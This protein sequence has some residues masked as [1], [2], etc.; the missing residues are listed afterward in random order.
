[1]NSES[2]ILLGKPNNDFVKLV[3]KIGENAQTHSYDLRLAWGSH[4]TVAR[5]TEKVDIGTLEKLIDLVG[6]GPEIKESIPFA[7]DVGYFQIN[8]SG[9]YFHTYKRFKFI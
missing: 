7:I 9:F 6:R 8:L 3:S 5:F 4:M 2:V 1:M